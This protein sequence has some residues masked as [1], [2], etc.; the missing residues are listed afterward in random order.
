MAGVLVGM[1]LLATPPSDKAVLLLVVPEQV[2]EISGPKIPGIS[3][4][5]VTILRSELTT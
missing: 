4:L 3:E 5:A 1:V 2:I